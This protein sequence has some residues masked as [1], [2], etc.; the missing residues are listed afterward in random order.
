MLNLQL[1]TRR[2]GVI[3]C[4]ILLGATLAGCG[5]SNSAPPPATPSAVAQFISFVMSIVGSGAAD[6]AEPTDISGVTPATT[7]TDEPVTL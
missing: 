5:H 2:L 1:S 7:E 6:I 4:G 3:A